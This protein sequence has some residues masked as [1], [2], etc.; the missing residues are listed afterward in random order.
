MLATS[1]APS[2]TLQSTIGDELIK[3]P[4]IWLIAELPLL[5]TLAGKEDSVA[6]RLR[7][8]LVLVFLVYRSE[9]LGVFVSGGP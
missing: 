7:S 2:L 5:K 4:L 8:L 3:L 6:G 9:S 1:L